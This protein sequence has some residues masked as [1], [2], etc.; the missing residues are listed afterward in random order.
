ML[1]DVLNICTL[2]ILGAVDDGIASSNRK[3]AHD[4]YLK[5]KSLGMSDSEALDFVTSKY[6][7]E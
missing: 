2:G 3:A 4:D 6:G 1:F 7:L 5:C